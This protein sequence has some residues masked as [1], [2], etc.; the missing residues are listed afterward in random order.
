MDEVILVVDDDKNLLKVTA[1][2]LKEEGYEVLTAD[3][4]EKAIELFDSKSVDLVLTDVKMPG[5]DG[6]ELLRHVQDKDPDMPV[7]LITAYAAI[8]SA[9]EAIKQGA[10]DYIP[11]PFEKDDLKHKVKRALEQKRLVQEN[12]RLRA[13]LAKREGMDEMVGR[14]RAMQELFEFI[15]RVAESDST[16]LISGESGTGKEL[17]ARAIHRSSARR[18]GPWITVNCAAI[19]RELLESDLF[20]HVKGAFTGA[21]KDQVGKFELA[22]GGSIFLDEVGD[23]GLDLQPKLLRVLQEREIQRVGSSHVKKVDVRVIAAS[24]A[25]LWEKV[26][27]GSFREDLYYRLAVIPIRVPPLRER[28]EDVPLLMGHFQKKYGMEKASWTTAAQ[29]TLEKYIW[30]GNVRELENL[31]ERLSV[32]HKGK[33]ISTREIPENIKK[34]QRIQKKTKDAVS[35]S[36]TEKQMIINAL[37]QASGNQ[38]EAA[39][40]LGIPRH[41]L[42]YRMKK[43]NIKPE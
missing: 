5:M 28:K 16:L 10:V 21:V 42:L 35:L 32:L 26:Q 3:S 4:A 31:V 1:Y 40:M 29:E 7:I 34:G 24:Q 14:S 17:V 43:Y 20:G 9:V 33:E 23:I 25:D 22:H 18:D 19:P 13:E 11:K 2:N 12:V 6:M 15:A 38:S 41:T 36:E 8:D 39:R 37:N 27:N 30:P